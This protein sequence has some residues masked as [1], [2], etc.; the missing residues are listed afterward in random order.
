MCFQAA[1]LRERV[2]AGVAG[3]RPFAAVR[4]EVDLE[5]TGRLEALAAQ[6]AAVRPLDCVVLL[7][8][9]QVGDG[10]DLLAAERARARK[11][12]RVRLEVLAE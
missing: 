6:A 11:G 1:V 8:R 9:A 4:L 2:T 10:A 3:E 7:V 5:V 12:R